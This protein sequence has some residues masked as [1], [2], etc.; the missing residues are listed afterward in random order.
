M[1]VSALTFVAREAK[2]ELRPASTQSAGDRVIAIDV[3]LEPDAKMVAKSEAANARLRENYP[4][5]Y[6]L[7]KKHVPHITL[8]QGYVR[9]KDLPWLKSTVSSLADA[10]Q[11][12]SWELTA[13]GYSYAI[14][15]GVAIT[16]ISIE[17]SRRL[18]MF[19]E[20]VAKA[21]NHERVANGTAAAFSTTREL[22]KIDQE[23]IDYVKNFAANSTGT[24]YNPH[25]TIGVAHEDFVKQLKAEPFE[26]FSFKPSGVA[27]YQLGN[28]GT[29]QRKLW[30]WHPKQ[31][32]VQLKAN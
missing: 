3:V 25:V 16:G 24:K 7:G 23:I 27:I 15:S 20:N 9:E 32:P 6:T 8:V 28:F 2:P 12:Q 11:P 13:T 4:K 18:E 10:T 30:E 22:P 26:K 21:V 5:G 1:I 29:A 19:E 17:P 14:W 31:K